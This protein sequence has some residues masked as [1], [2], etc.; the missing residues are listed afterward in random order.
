[1]DRATTL[2]AAVAMA[3]AFAALL[4]SEAFT[5]NSAPV[6][7]LTPGSGSRLAVDSVTGP[8]IRERFTQSVTFVPTRLANVH[9]PE[10]TVTYRR[11]FGPDRNRGFSASGG[12]VLP[13]DRLRESVGGVVGFG[14][15]AEIRQYV[16]RARRRAIEAYFSLGLEGSRAYYRA[17]IGTA[18]V[19]ETDYARIVETDAVSRRFEAS[20]GIGLELTTLHGFTL[21]FRPAVALNRVGWDARGGGAA[22][23]DGLIETSGGS[24]FRHY[25]RQDGRNG[26]NV[27]PRLRLG[28]GWAW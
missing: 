18:A 16:R 14:L 8:L 17:P 26:V 3:V 21:D 11:L 27:I 24:P 2:Q 1:M 19:P 5:Q 13:D 6:P 23:L 9:F 22:P 7:N 20:F 4:P 25:V 10:V 28:L 12:L 15:G